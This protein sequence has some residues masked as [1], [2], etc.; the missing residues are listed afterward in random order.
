VKKE[1]KIIV[2]VLA[3]LISVSMNFAANLTSHM[4]NYGHSGTSNLRPANWIE[5]DSGL[6]SGYGVGQI[7]VGMNDQDA[8]WA[9][10][11]DNTGVISDQFTKSIDGGLTWT[12]GTFNAGIGLSQLFAID[13]MT[14]WAVFNTGANQGLYKT[15]DGGMNWV[16]MNAGFG[17]NS[18]ANV[19]HFFSEDDG[20]AQG[21]PVGGY[22]ELYTTDDGG[23]NWTRVPQG[24]IPD[25]TTGEYGITGNYY[26]VGDNIWWGTN[27]GRIFYSTDKGYTWSETMTSFGATEVV[28]CIFSDEMNGFAFRSYLDMGIEP[29]INVTTDGGQTYAAVFV[30]GDMYAR[31]FSFV[32]GTTSTFV[33]TSSTSGTEGASYS[34]DGGYNWITLNSSVP[35]Q[36]TAFLDTETGWSGTWAG[37]TGGMYIFD[38][39]L[40]GATG[41]INGIVTDIN[42]G[43]AIENAVITL[44]E[45]TTYTDYSGIY[46]MIL[47][48]GTYNLICEMDGYETYTQDNVIIEEG[49]ITTINIQM[50]NIFLPPLNFSG[51]YNDPIVLLVW[52]PPSSD[53]VGYRIY[54]NNEMIQE[55]NNTAA[56][57][58]IDIEP[59]IGNYCYNITAIYSGGE[60]CFSNSA[61]VAVCPG[62]GIIEGSITLNSTQGNI[63]EAL[64]QFDVFNFYPDNTGYFNTPS[65]A[66]N[67]DLN[68]SLNGYG[69]IFLS[70]LE[71]VENLTTT[72]DLNLEILDIPENLNLVVSENDIYLEWDMLDN[73]NRTLSGYKIYRNDAMLA[74]I[75]DPGVMFYNDNSLEAG[76]YSYFITAVFNEIDESF[77]SNEESIDVVLLP[78]Q[79]LIVES[80][81]PDIL[82]EWEVPNYTRYLTGYR[83]YRND[84]FFAEL[85]DTT[86]IDLNVITGTYTYY[87]TAMYGLHES[88]PSNVE[89]IDHTSSIENTTISVSKLIDNYPNPFNPQTLI[90]Y[91]I[92]ISGE[93]D[94]SVYNIKG[95]NIITL[96]NE[97]KEVGN[98]SINW[99][100]VDKIGKPVS[101]GL[102]FYKLKLNNKSIAIKKCLLLK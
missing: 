87:V 99:N 65:V 98:H 43:A 11:I 100:G 84:N 59:P 10:A 55:I 62:P 5:T 29:Q 68:V 30:S 41:T 45:L 17:S 67:Y 22:Y 8:L 81:S 20:F 89:S 71:I 50:Q 19:I 82:L 70:D 74:E 91:S 47:D 101:S 12:A 37:A 97:Y 14:C 3:I 2:I 39:N 7:S 90:N 48:V 6:P 49:Q 53:F 72:V 83:I 23:D 95:Q 96:I 44:G 35:I 31:W 92:A 57:L 34:E 24:D 38:G 76:S 66:G 42:T 9:Y 52:D 77:S 1:F 88:E 73:R 4:P 18:F 21:D 78:P 64:I 25:P 85:N 28:S 36:A 94:I 46:S 54:R 56:T 86:Y 13:D 93:V 32:P 79:N 15:I 63:E 33:G 58:F 26:A 102:Y 80:Q 40:N 61:N 60:S 51:E 16:N 27:Q 75:S 69:T